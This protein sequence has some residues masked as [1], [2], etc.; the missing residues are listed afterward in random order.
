MEEQ[1]LAEIEKN[2]QEKQQELI[3]EQELN[4]KQMAD[5]KSEFTKLV[6]IKK[7]NAEIKKENDEIEH[8]LD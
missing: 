1:E 7:K 4:Q 6:T 2:I 8:S 3:K 5:Y